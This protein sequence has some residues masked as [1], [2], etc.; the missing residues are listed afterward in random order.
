MLPALR[1][2]LWCNFLKEASHT[3]SISLVG[4]VIAMAFFANCQFI[5]S[6]RRP[7]VNRTLN[8]EPKHDIILETNEL[9]KKSCGDRKSNKSFFTFFSRSLS[10]FH[11]LTHS[12][13]INEIAD[14]IIEL[15]LCYK[16]HFNWVNDERVERLTEGNLS[17]IDWW[18]GS[19]FFALN[20][21]FV[22]M[23]F[24]N[25]QRREIAVIKG[26]NLVRRQ[27]HV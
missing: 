13:F 3:N 26:K 24:C 17:M 18:Q 11:S 10:L 5:E 21:H 14:V 2:P 22:K 4:N 8:Y 20:E 23:G 9:M 16:L 25:F 7:D 12:L 1:R 15:D 27:S 6:N 19:R